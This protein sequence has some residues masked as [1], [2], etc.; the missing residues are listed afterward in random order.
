MKA[1]CVTYK[2]EETIRLY[3]YIFKKYWPT[4]DMT[5][6]GH[7]KPHELEYESDFIKY[8]NIYKALEYYK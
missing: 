5:I 1:Y 3:E 4:V 6:L 8:K 2:E 7:K